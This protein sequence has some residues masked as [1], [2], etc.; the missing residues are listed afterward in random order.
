MRREH[1]RALRERAYAGGVAD[2]ARAAVVDLDGLAQ[3]R[4]AELGRVQPVD[5]DRVV[6]LQILDRAFDEIPRPALAGREIEA[7]DAD[8]LGAAVGFAPERE[9]HHQLV[10]LRDAGHGQR[11]EAATLVE[12]AGDVDVGRA[13][14]GDPQVGVGMVDEAGGGAREA[15]QQAE[16]DTH[17]QHGE[18]HADQGHDEARAVVAEIAPGQQAGAA[19]AAGVD[20]AHVRRV[21][22]GGS[23]APSLGVSRRSA[24]CSSAPN[25]CCRPR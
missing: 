22:A 10:D 4:D 24:A 13:G 15:E 2:H 21:P 1:V 7:D 9:L 17:Q 18:Q 20:A 23:S 25:N 12:P 6:L 11:L 19:D 3:R 8:A 14:R 16:F 5:D